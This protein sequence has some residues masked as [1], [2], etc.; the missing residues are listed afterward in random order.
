MVELEPAYVDILLLRFNAKWIENENGCWLWQT[1]L[2][3]D[4]YG[5]VR[6]KGKFGKTVKAHRLSWFLFTGS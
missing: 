6:L 2:N 4:G 3:D 5:Q 1:S